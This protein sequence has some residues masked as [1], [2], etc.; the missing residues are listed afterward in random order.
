MKFRA[1]IVDIGC[2]HQFIK[3]LS[4]LTKITKTCTMK[5]SESHVVF[6]QC[7]RIIGGGTSMW[8]EINQ[9]DYFDEYRI[10]G[11]DESNL[12]FLEVVNENL[13]RAMKSAQN[14]QSV[15]MKLT[16]KQTPCL[17]FEV[18]LPSLTSHTRSVIHDIPVALIPSRY[19]DDFAKPTFLNYD[20]QV[21]L[22]Q[23]R[24]LKNIVERMKNLSGFMVVSASRDGNLQFKVETDDV[25]ATTH[26]KNMIHNKPIHQLSDDSLD[27]RFEA[28]VDINKLVT[29]L[30]VQLFNPTNSVCG[31][32]NGQAVQLFVQ[33]NDVQ[34]QYYIPA[35]NLT[36]T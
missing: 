23:L 20:I 21:N 24:V 9:D 15:K 5:L 8:C 6:T 17:T 26:F 36:M 29:F 34:F 16:K 3:I 11:K 22:P 10:E 18:I 2:I 13:I 33:C 12:I 28:R 4:A 27:D 1:K 7:E 35:I 30:H 14:A 19:W 32:V 31:I 25:T